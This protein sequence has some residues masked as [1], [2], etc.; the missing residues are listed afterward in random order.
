MS[1]STRLWTI[2]YKAIG[3]VI[4]ALILG[5]LVLVSFN[6]A[7]LRAE[8]QA[9]YAD[10]QASQE[11]AER[12]YEQLLTLPGVEPEGEDPADV[13]PTTVPGDPG[14]RG[15]AGPPGA[16]GEPGIPGDPGPPGPP[17]PDGMPGTNGPA[18]SDGA[19][20]SEGAA[21]PAG[22][23]GEPGPP[24]EQ[25]APGEPGPQGPPG[26]AC[27]DGYTLTPVF[28]S[29]DPLIFTGTPAL[30]CLPTVP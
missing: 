1:R 9:M 28:V 10:L 13:A 14:E 3:A 26:P 6:N 22:P 20:G 15:S 30:A 7:Q 5:G 23:A 16:D 25:G 12:L 4:V 27:P 8:N 21:G 24:G 17:G 19:A 11:N 18:G 2:A 29:T